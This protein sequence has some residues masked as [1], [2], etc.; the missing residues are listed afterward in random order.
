MSQNRC[1]LGPYIKIKAKDIT[2]P[3]WIHTCTNRECEDHKKYV[4]DSK[5]CPLCASPKDKLELNVKRRFDVMDVLE[6]HKIENDFYLWNFDDYT[7]VL[8][9]KYQ[10]GISIKNDGA[11]PITNTTVASSFLHPDWTNIKAIFLAEQ[12]E[13]EP[14]IGVVYYYD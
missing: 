13:F 3:I 8:P 7:V 5:F 12:I 2:V 6:K 10:C 4:S 11:Y 14:E 1:Y 9:N